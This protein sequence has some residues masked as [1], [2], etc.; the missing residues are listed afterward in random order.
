VVVSH[1]PILAVPLKSRA[2]IRVSSP[3]GAFPDVISFQWNMKVLEQRKSKRQP[4]ILGIVSPKR[5]SVIKGVACA[6][7]RG[8]TGR[9]VIVGINVL[10]PDK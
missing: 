4:T 8:V 5:W 1:I 9:H 6:G 10:Y 3:L 2:P 7:Y